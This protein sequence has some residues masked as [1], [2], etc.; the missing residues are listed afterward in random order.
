MEVANRNEIKFG[1]AKILLNLENNT[2]KE[3]N[4][5]IEK[6]YKNNNTN[7]KSMLFKVT[8]EDLLSLTGG[9]IQ[10]NEW[11]SNYTRWKVY[12]SSNTCSCK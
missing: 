10:R 4:I 7:N 9:I 8:D 6:I 3:Y 1:D 5:K 12:R 11:C 2:K